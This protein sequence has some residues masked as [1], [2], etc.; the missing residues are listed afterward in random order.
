MARHASV[1][2][3]T[4]SDTLVMEWNVLVKEDYSR[5]LEQQ[6]EKTYL[7]TVNCKDIRPRRE[8]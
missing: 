2:W 1:R 6:D 4:E 7:P 3:A 5:L 8:K